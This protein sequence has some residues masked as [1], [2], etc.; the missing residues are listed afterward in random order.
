MNLD[1]I[2]L[3]LFVFEMEFIREIGGIW[4]HLADWDLIMIEIENLNSGLSIQ[5]YRVE[6]GNDT[7]IHFPSLKHLIENGKLTGDYLNL[8]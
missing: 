4:T 8:S 7:R 6:G 3:L 5:L 2:D 1:L